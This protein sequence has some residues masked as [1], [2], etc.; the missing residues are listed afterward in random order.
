M[1]AP[2]EAHAMTLGSWIYMLVAWG[3]IIAVN[4]FCFYRI[5]GRKH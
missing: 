3:L 4:V 1:S 5:F 2:I